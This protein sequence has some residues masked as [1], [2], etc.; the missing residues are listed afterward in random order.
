MLI[1]L[2]NFEV[3]VRNCSLYFQTSNSEDLAQCKRSPKKPSLEGINLFGMKTELLIANLAD[4][5]FQSI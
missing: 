3:E 2:F 5:N 1:I 4:I